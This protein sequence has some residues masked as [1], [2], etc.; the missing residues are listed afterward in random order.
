MRL[1]VLGEDGVEGDE[2]TE[3]WDGGGYRQLIRWGDTVVNIILGIEPSDPLAYTS[4]LELHQPIMI[5]IGG[6]GDQLERE[7]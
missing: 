3:G 4:V 5:M 6:N 7:T 2:E 1:A